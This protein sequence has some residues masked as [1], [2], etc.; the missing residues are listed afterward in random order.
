MTETTIL[1]LKYLTWAL[2]VG[3]AFAGSWFFEFT[4]TD[5]DTGRRS[6]TPWGRRGIVFAA[7]SL[8]C[9]FILTVWTDRDAARKQAEA[10]ER[11]VAERREIENER[12]T[13]AAYRD[14]FEKGQSDTNELLRLLSQNIDKFS[15]SGK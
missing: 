10:A 1:I 15:D 4:K 13:S 7:L 14:K 12:K 6:L 8:A 3:T 5:K 11:A 9:A 2:T